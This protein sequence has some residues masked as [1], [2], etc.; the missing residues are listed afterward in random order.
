MS[1][2]LLYPALVTWLMP[3]GCNLLPALAGIFLYRF[4]PLFAKMLFLLSFL[5]L[6]IMSSPI[7]AYN[8]IETLQN[9]YPPLNPEKIDIKTKDS[10][11]VVLGAGSAISVE[12]G[13]K[14]TV[15]TA[16][17]NRLRYA[18]FLHKKT[19]FPIIVSGGQPAG[20]LYNEADLMAKT[21][22]DN[23]GVTSTLRENQGRNTMGESQY[24]AALLKQHH[25]KTIYLVTHA[26]HMPRSMHAFEKQG[27]HVIPAPMG[28]YVY[29]HRYSVL[30]YL[31]NIHA[32]HAM[33]LFMHEYIGLL[34]YQLKHARG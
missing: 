17:Y 5:S 12:N 19:H 15:S 18:V 34:W 29:D 14:V 3:P 21:L 1:F 26:W 4:Y 7:F 8:M 13:R 33:S 31:P 22:Q 32:L 27:M 11:I 20:T 16:E 6:W 9:Q 2:A 23:F 25:I 24:M 28:F 30:S 10:A